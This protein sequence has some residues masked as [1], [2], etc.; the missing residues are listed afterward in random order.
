MGNSQTKKK[1]PQVG[2]TA[3]RSRKGESKART[4]AGPRARGIKDLKRRQ[5]QV[6]WFR[7]FMQG[8]FSSLKFYVGEVVFFLAYLYVQGKVLFEAIFLDLPR[9]S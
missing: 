1:H 6:E 7:V 4:E 3:Y 9:S 8:P 5:N 2:L